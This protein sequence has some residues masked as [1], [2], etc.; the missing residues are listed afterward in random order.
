[1]LSFHYLNYGP[2]PKL[3]PQ[4]AF[5]A[6]WEGFITPDCNVGGVDDGVTTDK[7]SHNANS[8]PSTGD[9]VGPGSGVDR[10]D[11]YNT[12][13]AGARAD[14][15]R[16]GKGLGALF[17]WKGRGAGNLTVWLDGAAVLGCT[18]TKGNKCQLQ[19]PVQGAPTLKLEP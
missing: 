18:S 5:A 6:R 17:N 16:V 7:T 12:A 9:D 2:D 8:D 15:T 4:S 3:L 13:D 19:V 11:A 10:T 1:M 14:N